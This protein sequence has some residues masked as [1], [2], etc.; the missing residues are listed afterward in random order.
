MKKVLL[1]MALIATMAQ[2]ESIVHYDQNIK[3][4]TPVSKPNYPNNDIYVIR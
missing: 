4:D 1:A 2:A 3:G